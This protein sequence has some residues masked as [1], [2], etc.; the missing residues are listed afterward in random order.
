MAGLVTTFAPG[1]VLPQLDAALAQRLREEL[2][3]G[4]T[5]AISP[6]LEAPEEPGRGSEAGGDPGLS[7]KP[8][9]KLAGALQAFK[10]ELQE[11]A[12]KL[13]DPTNGHAQ[14]VKRSYERWPADTAITV[15]LLKGHL[16]QLRGVGEA[17]A[18]PRGEAT[19]AL[20]EEVIRMHLR[21][22]SLQP[23][24]RLLDLAEGSAPFS[25]QV[26]ELL[27]LVMP[28]A[29][30]RKQHLQE[31]REAVL[32]LP[33]GDNRKLP[34]AESA[35]LQ[36]EL[37]LWRLSLLC[38]VTP[39]VL[40]QGA[41]CPP[42]TDPAPPPPVPPLR[43]PSRRPMRAILADLQAEQAQGQ[44]TGL[45]AGRRARQEPRADSGRQEDGQSREMLEPE[46]AKKKAREDKQREGE[47][48]RERRASQERSRSQGQ[49]RSRSRDR[50]RSRSR[51]RRRSPPRD[52]RDSRSRQDRGR[53]RSRRSRS[54]SR[55][56]SR[57]RG[58]SAR[59][60]PPRGQGRQGKSPSRA[61]SS[62]SSRSRSRTPESRRSPP[63][64]A[65]SVRPPSE[66]PEDVKRARSGGSA[67]NLAHSVL[68]RNYRMV[69]END[70]SKDPGT[71]GAGTSF[72]G[73]RVQG[74]VLLLAYQE[75]Q[76]NA[77]LF[78]GPDDRS[79]GRLNLFDLFSRP[80]LR[81]ARK[82]YLENSNNRACK[83]SCQAFPD[84]FADIKTTT[85]NATRVIKLMEHIATQPNQPSWMVKR[86]LQEVV[87][88]AEL[89]G[90]VLPQLTNHD[91]RF[92]A[93]AGAYAA[94]CFY[95]YFASG[96][97]MWL[98]HPEQSLWTE[99]GQRL[100]LHCS[101][102]HLLGHLSGICEE[103]H[104][105]VSD[106]RVKPTSAQQYPSETFRALQAKQSSKT[107]QPSPPR[108][109]GRGGGSGHQRG[110][111]NEYGGSS[112]HQGPD[113]HGSGGPQQHNRGH[114]G[115]ERP[116]PRNQGS[117]YGNAGGGRHPHYSNDNRRR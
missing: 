23:L 57:N 86:A 43:P 84:F 94:C 100:G 78:G 18:S 88:V 26:P 105:S 36:L 16:R 99:V 89:I 47:A 1:A 25:A 61:R 107:K 22:R 21:L 93:Q 4:G 114:Q 7:V 59:R 56:R 9:R 42:L 116:P 87:W 91:R 117:Q 74:S 106:A 15:G 64:A 51:D 96:D 67:V 24:L 104:G 40:G 13:M 38:A 115:N 92:D 72:M 41:F 53:S 14:L 10:A 52:Q 54:R 70:L 8:H 109:G 11:L 17:E 66:T 27:E 29:E 110:G 80:E 31:L 82:S 20:P 85:T 37:L 77:V 35:M 19:E 34:D 97:R 3:F 33:Q 101:K 95:L 44:D 60:S 73:T 68:L 111:S 62:S 39:A 63:R 90:V 76:Q 79:A 102:C 83:S 58:R 103:L 108:G 2:P 65:G 12:T 5:P 6:Y 30:E 71:K 50:P 48:Q 49:H 81:L 112:R 45:G 75:C 98:I 55:G 32:Q 113:R 46:N 69:L 28:E